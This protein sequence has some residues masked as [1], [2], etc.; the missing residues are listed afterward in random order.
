MLV[1]GL[2]FVERF[3]SLEL[4]GEVDFWLDF[5]SVIGGILARRIADS[6]FG[7]HLVVESF[8]LFL[9]Y[10]EIPDWV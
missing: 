7:I 2:V 1:L 4:V 5:A 10:W 3:V 8:F 9:Y 6:L